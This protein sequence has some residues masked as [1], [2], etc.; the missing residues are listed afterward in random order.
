VTIS[1]VARFRPS[2]RLLLVDAEYLAPATPKDAIWERM[3]MARPGR[4]SPVFTPMPQDPF[5]GVGAFFGIWP[6]SESDEELLRALA[7]CA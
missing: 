2:G 1:G 4:A 6:G 7:E 5:S 3:P